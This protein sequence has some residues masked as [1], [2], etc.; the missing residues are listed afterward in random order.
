MVDFTRV[1]LGAQWLIPVVGG[2]VYGGQAS[3]KMEARAEPAAPDTLRRFHTAR[4]GLDLQV[5]DAVRC[6]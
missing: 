3:A 5:G 1:G 2:H 6:L 4:S